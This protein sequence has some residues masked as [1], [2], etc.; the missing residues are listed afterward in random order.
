MAV[1]WSTSRSQTMVDVRPGGAGNAWQIFD[2]QSEVT[3]PTGGGQ[4]VDSRWGRSADG[5]DE[6]KGSV[7]TDNPQRYEFDL[8][9]RLDYAQ[10]SFIKRL[11]CPADW[12]IRQRCGDVRDLTNYL[13]VIEYIDGAITGNSYS[14]PLA[15]NAAEPG[16]DE[17]D[18]F[19]I[20]AGFEVRE[21]K[22]VHLDVTKSNVDAVIN[23]VISVGVPICPGDCGPEVTGEEEF[24]DVT[25]RDSTP[26]YF[27]QA[28]AQF[29][30]TLDSGQT[31]SYSYI[32]QFQ[33]ADAL[34]LVKLGPRVFAVSPQGGV[35][36][37]RIEDIK[38]GVASPWTRALAGGTNGPRA[39][40]V[41][42]NGTL[43]AAGN[44]GFVY[45]SIDGG[46]TWTTFDAGVTTTQ[47]INTIAVA[48]D[49]LVWFGAN[50]GVL[51]RYFGQVLSRVTTGLTTA[52]NTA[53][54]PSG[55]EAEL[56]F[57]TADGRI[58]RTRAST[59]STPTF[60]AMTFDGSGSGAVEDL[61]FAGIRG[62]V[63]FVVQ[64][65]SDGK[66]RVLRDLSGGNLSNDVEVVASYDSPVQNGINSIA[67]ANEN[68]AITVGELVGGFGFT[69]VVS[70]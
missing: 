49:D 22:L 3:A 7:R 56:Y 69:G 61:Q 4:P 35:A 47:Q 1:Q 18:T 58:F 48:N 26:G 63:L 20:S 45:R 38:N 15:N 11:K 19:S 44:N 34:G 50:N 32:N 10:R 30:Y 29:G 27:A 36:Y 62:N 64:S 24:W 40:A 52:I 8:M 60:T 55:R 9:K 2:M 57:G 17:M 37:A 12:R 5:S 39:I 23:K 68:F 14:A 21:K 25:N 65:R 31:W 28:T 41:T 43:W 33:N 53:A 42:P 54:V 16:D 13:A 66:S 6:Y 46:F 51:M 70:T 59:A 67:P